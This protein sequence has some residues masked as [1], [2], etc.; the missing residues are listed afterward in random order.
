MKMFFVDNKSV[1]LYGG[2]AVLELFLWLFACITSCFITFY[3]FK[4]NREDII[5]GMINFSI[6]YWTMYFVFVR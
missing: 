6:G 5:T 1:D 3:V 4:V 2:I